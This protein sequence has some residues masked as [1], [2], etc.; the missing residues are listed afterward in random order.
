MPEGVDVLALNAELFPESA[1]VYDSLS[2]AYIRAGDEQRAIELAEKS[3]AM[4]PRDASTPERKDAIRRSAQEKLARL[5][6][7]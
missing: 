4:L 6:K 1:N 5:K 2:D 3:L 7:N